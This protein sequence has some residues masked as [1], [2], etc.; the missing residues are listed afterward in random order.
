MELAGAAT[1]M[2]VTRFVAMVVTLICV[3]WTHGAR[4]DHLRAFFNST[5]RILHVTSGNCHQ[6][7]R[8]VTAAYITRLMA[9]YGETRS[10]LVRGRIESV[11]AAMMFALSGSI[12]PFV[13]QNLGQNEL[14]VCVLVS[15]QLSFSVAWGLVVPFRCFYSATRIG[16]D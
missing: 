11:A 4:T 6:S 10:W 1:A 9:N 3:S 16:L 7:D 5:K 8:A 15:G 12:G 2:T 13:V 14:I